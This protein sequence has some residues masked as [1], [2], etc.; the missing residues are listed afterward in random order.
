MNETFITHSEI[1]TF[2]NKRVNLPAETAKE[3]R[4]QV[5]NLREKLEAYIAENPG[6]TLLKMLHAGSVAK[7]TALKT[8]NDLDVAVYVKKEDVPI[9]EQDLVP[10]FAARLREAYPQLEPEQ[11][12]ETSP[13]CVKVK[14]RG[15]G[16]DVDVVPVLYEG[17]EDDRGYLVNKKTGD[18]LLTSIPLHLEFIR[19][20]KKACPDHYAQMVR[21]VKWWADQRKQENVNFKCK[22]FMIELIMAKLLDDGADLSDYPAALELFFSEIVKGGLEEQITFIDYYPENYQFSETNAPISI[23]DP[24]NADNNIAH[25]YSLEDRNALVQAA[26]EAADAISEAH[27]ATTK[28]RS[29]ECWQK[30]FGR[31]FSAQV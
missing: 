16:L 23:I 21:L 6:F 3:H 20:R 12:D 1:V 14:F 11:F 17:G 5:N 9:R 4:L 15:S 8:L 31:S 18:R 2:A 27:Y 29:V 24:V 30:V 10:W 7:G 25:K 28:E 26:E 13:N 19:T 22:S